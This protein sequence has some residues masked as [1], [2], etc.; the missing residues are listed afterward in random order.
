MKRITSNVDKQ[1]GDKY[2]ILLTLL[3][4]VRG[5]NE[6]LKEQQNRPLKEKEVLDMLGIGAKTLRSYRTNGLL[7][8]SKIGNRFFY[9]QSD[10]DRML[11]NARIESD[12]SIDA[13]G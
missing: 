8:Y 1:P 11:N 3:K 9:R 13:H 6:N 5:L 2:D 4:E 12:N 10:I 7:A